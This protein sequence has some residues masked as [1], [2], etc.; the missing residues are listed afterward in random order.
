MRASGLC[1]VSQNNGN[2]RSFRGRRGRA[3]QDFSFFFSLS[4][5][6]FLSFFSLSLFLSFSHI[7][8]SPYDLYCGEGK[9]LCVIGFL[10]HRAMG[11]A[12]TS[13]EIWT[14]RGLL[15]VHKLFL[16]QKERWLRALAQTHLWVLKEKLFPWQKL[17]ERRSSA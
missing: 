4:F 12:N 1:I 11:M 16:S 17:N 13:K 14:T 15:S 5:L 7:F 3:K 10:G 2:R 6:F 9:S 8:L